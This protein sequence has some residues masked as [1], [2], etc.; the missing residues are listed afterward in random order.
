AQPLLLSSLLQEGIQEHLDG[1]FCITPKLTRRIVTATMRGDLSA[2]RQDT[3]TMSRFLTT[4]HEYGVFPAMTAILN[5]RGV[6]GS[7]APRP[8]RPL[9]EHMKRRLLDEPAVI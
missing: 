8:Y 9:A 4:L 3:E 5:S 7:F 2:A 6:P 1:V